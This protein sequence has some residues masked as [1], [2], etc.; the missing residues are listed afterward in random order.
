M[1]IFALC[2]SNLSLMKHDVMIVLPSG[3]LLESFVRFGSTRSS[4]IP[5]HIEV[6]GVHSFGLPREE[7]DCLVIKIYRK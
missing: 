1:F 5:S 7:G 2:N 3:Y 6:E 4:S